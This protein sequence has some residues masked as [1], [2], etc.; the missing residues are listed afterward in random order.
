M[1]IILVIWIT[2]INQKGTFFIYEISTIIA[3]IMKL[4][5]QGPTPTV[6]KKKTLMS[7]RITLPNSPFFLTFF[8]S[9]TRRKRQLLSLPICFCLLPRM[10]QKNYP[11]TPLF[12]LLNQGSNTRL[13][14]LFSFS[15]ETSSWCLL[16]LKW[17]N[18]LSLGSW[19][20]FL[21]SLS[22]LPLLWDGPANSFINGLM[23]FYKATIPKER[24][25][26]LTGKKREES[27]GFGS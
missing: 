2:I 8:L 4:Q 13:S 23:A 25:L 26:A 5:E 6:V 16:S 11:E 17:P 10:I 14:S 9:F 7:L 19:P 24:G 22:T 27:F 12:Q 1:W 21:K 3:I 18:V 20:L 15:K